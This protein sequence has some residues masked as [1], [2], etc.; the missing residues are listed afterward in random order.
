MGRESCTPASGQGAG[1]CIYK[2]I[3]KIKSLSAFWRSP[4]E[5]LVKHTLAPCKA[6]P[7]ADAETEN[8]GVCW[9]PVLNSVDFEHCKVSCIILGATPHTLLQPL[10]NH[11]E[12]ATT[13]SMYIF[14]Q[15]HKI[16]VLCSHVI[17]YISNGWKRRCKEPKDKTDG[18]S[19]SG[20]FNLRLKLNL[21]SALKKPAPCSWKAALNCT[22]SGKFFLSHFCFEFN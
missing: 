4:G 9:A 16:L 10:C 8:P 20:K 3:Y 13:A 19:M 21:K 12:I 7:Q 1:E 22:H 15:K 2:C 18:A 5:S 17:S 6:S 11:M 14:L